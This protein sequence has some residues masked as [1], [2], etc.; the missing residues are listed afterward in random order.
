MVDKIRRPGMV[1]LDP[2]VRAQIDAYATETGAT[3][4]NGVMNMI[5]RQWLN[6]RGR[7]S[8]D[9]AVEEVGADISEWCLGRRDSIQDTGPQ[10]SGRRYSYEDAARYARTFTADRAKA[11]KGGR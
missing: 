6:T 5:V 2:A 9:R 7:E 1:R 8:A 4:F 3:S 10:A 11:L